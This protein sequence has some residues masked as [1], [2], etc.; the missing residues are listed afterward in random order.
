MGVPWVLMLPQ[1]GESWKHPA[2]PSH[3]SAP[4]SLGV[5]W[6]QVI[7]EIFLFQS[8]GFSHLPQNV[9]QE[10]LSYSLLATTWL[11]LGDMVRQGKKGG[12]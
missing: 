8:E 2:V 12:T 1:E 5:S 9:L 7:S 4:Q 6:S 11:P 3:I 10:Q